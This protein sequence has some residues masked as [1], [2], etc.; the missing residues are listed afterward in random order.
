MGSFTTAASKSIMD[1]IFPTSTSSHTALSSSTTAVSGYRIYNSVSGTANQ[2]GIFCA[3]TP[4]VHRIDL[5]SGTNT[6]GNV[7]PSVLLNDTNF[8]SDT[9]NI[10]SNSPT[11]GTINFPNTSAAPHYY[12]S[13]KGVLAGDTGITNNSWTGW[14]LSTTSNKG[15][16]INNNQIAF[17]AMTSGTSAGITAWGFCISA[18]TSTSST[19][20][21]GTTVIAAP[22]AGTPVIIAYGD[23]SQSR[24]IAVGDTPV[25]TSGAIVITLE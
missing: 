5:I 4:V 12:P 19:C 16:A 18:A 13:Y 9:L 15:Q 22:T 21:S 10:S 20:A 14:T 8:T 25:F 2:I 23:L 24:S 1:A 7:A 6:S 11:A 17:P 3:A